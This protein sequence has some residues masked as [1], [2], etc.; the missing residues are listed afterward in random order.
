MEF[1]IK[2]RVFFKN[3]V[4]AYAI[5][6]AFGAGSARAVAADGAT[7]LV[8]A[9]GGGPTNL[10]PLKE[11]VGPMMNVWTLIFEGL[12]RQGADGSLQPALASGWTAI[13]DTI[14]E[15][16]LRPGVTF[17]N[18]EA[19]DAE[20]VKFT[21][22]RVLDP[23]FA[24][25]ARSRLQKLTQVE[26]VDP[27]TVRLHSDG[28]DPTILA[29][30]G[31]AFVV[32]PK[33][34]R[35]KGDAFAAQHPVGTGPFKFQAWQQGEFID[36]VANAKYHDAPPKIASLKIRQIQD[37]STRVA[38]LLSGESNIA[39]QVP[40][41]LVRTLKQNPDIN[42]ASVGALMALVIEFDTVRGPLKDKRL[43][44]AINYAIDKD[45]LIRDLLAGQGNPLQGQ[46]LTPGAFGFNQAL[47]PY[48][49]DLAKAKQLIAEA[50]Y[51]NGLELNLTTPVGRYIGDREV[52]IAVAGQLEK[53][54][55]KVNVQPQEWGVFVKQL[56]SDGLGPMFLVGWYS[57]GDA[58][59]VMTHFTSSSSFGVY[60]KN[61]AFDALVQE[62]RTQT[63]TARRTEIYS[64]ATEMMFEEAPAA[65]L[66]QLP[67]TY[68]VTS[69]VTGFVPRSDERWDLS[70]VQIKS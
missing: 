1:L 23:A 5:S 10:D 6:V 35:E 17:H 44:Q 41:D 68:G 48:P 3:A 12:T 9:Q 51:P 4:S 64:K 15:M 53:A 37:D 43:R 29:G 50:G 18:G 33:Y 47:H 39:V 24:S 67:T 40:P 42:V 49:Y 34:T 8:I 30:L 52:A 28:P 13:S 45:S 69:N 2:R 25:Q 19:F 36:L 22:D 26:I 57:Y 66:L 31:W 65:F 59:F 16:K 55:I 21:L 32:P 7:T 63:D 46:I 54:G 58:A 60:Q 38:S 11:Q 20:A 14:W 61:P 56:R 70:K 62:G 27:M